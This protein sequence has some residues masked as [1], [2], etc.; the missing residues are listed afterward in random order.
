MDPIDSLWNMFY[1]IFKT[2]GNVNDTVKYINDT[3]LK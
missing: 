2:K 3:Y 1:K